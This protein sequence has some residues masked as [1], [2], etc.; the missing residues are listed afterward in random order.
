MPAILDTR[1]GCL[2]L[3][4]SDM[5]GETTPA[6]RMT[7]DTTGKWKMELIN[8]PEI[9]KALGREVLN[10]F[11]RCFVHSD[12]LTSMVSCIHASEQHHGPDS[13]AHRRDHLS[14]VWFT[15]GTLREL[16]RAIGV[17]HDALYKRDWLDPESKH[18]AVLR[19]LRRRWEKDAVFRKVRDRAAFH[20]DSEV[21]DKGLNEL[22]KHHVIELAEGQGEKNID[23]TLT[24]GDLA[25]LVGLELSADKFRA[26][27]DK[28]STDH[29]AATEAVQLAF[30]DAAKA[31]G[32][33]HD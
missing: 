7:E 23:S 14:M 11:C 24:L 15:I 32:V 25:L 1:R 9:E 18:W 20:V 21:I 8:F 33:S 10:A 5:T 17:A 4:E 2:A 29:F 12:R 30:Y 19:E 26:F 28:V 13:T 22:V 16:A 27:M 6:I 3:L 31:A